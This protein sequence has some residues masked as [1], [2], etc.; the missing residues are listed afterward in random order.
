V[1]SDPE[2]TSKS[3][4]ERPAIDPS[5]TVRDSELGPWSEVGPRTSIVESTF[6]A[7]SYVT[8]DS[9]IIYSRIGRFCSIASHVRINPGNHPTWRAAQHHFLYRA[10]AYDLGD[11]EQAFFDWRREHRV[12]I[13]HDV[14]IGHGAIVLPGRR[15]GSGAVIGA[16][17]VVT[18]D[19][20]PYTIVA[21]NPA[22]PI[23]PR[24][25]QGIA[26]AL[27]D[28]AWWHW[29]REQ[30]RGALQDFRDLPVADFVRKH[31]R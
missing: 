11:D 17:S 21:G 10:S 19:V 8:S 29:D 9:Q 12:D 16:G 27:L 5:A 24:F 31:A 2:S 18:H 30:L 7:Y 1:T 28:L 15:I 22:R 14:W 26:D 4:G 25:P 23:R 20:D 6:D 3:L 13:G